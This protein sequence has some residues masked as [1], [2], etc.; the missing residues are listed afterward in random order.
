M[1]KPVKQIKAE[2]AQKAKISQVG[3][4][5][6]YAGESR[7]Q[8]CCGCL[9]EFSDCL[10]LQFW[11]A[12]PRIVCKKCARELLGNLFHMSVTGLL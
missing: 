9:K 7:R 8:E 11:T 1:A 2:I 5:S 3:E 10:E 12:D 4:I 6:I